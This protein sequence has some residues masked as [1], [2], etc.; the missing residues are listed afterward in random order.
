MTSKS[1]DVRIKRSTA[2]RLVDEI[3]A[4]IL[5]INSNDELAYKV[6]RAVLFGSYINS[7]CET[8]SDIDLGIMIEPRLI[9]KE[10]QHLLKKERSKMCKSGDWFVVMA[11]PTTEIYRIIRGSSKYISIHDFDVDHEAIFDKKTMEL[12]V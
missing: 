4:R 10:K 11:Y 5:E 8:L 12:H 9:D 7:D 2:D 1:K 3:Q 6:T